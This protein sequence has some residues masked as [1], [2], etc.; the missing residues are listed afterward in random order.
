MLCN[1]TH[2]EVLAELLEKLE[3]PVESQ[4][5]VFSKTSAQNSRIAPETPRAIYFS[6]DL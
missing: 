5:L 6:D 3:V 2:R 1:G 4:V